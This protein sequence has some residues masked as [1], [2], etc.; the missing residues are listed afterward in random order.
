MAIDPITG[1]ET[2][3]NPILD[4]PTEG[5]RPIWAEEQSV[6]D[7][8]TSQE[9]P[10]EDEFLK[11]VEKEVLRAE[12]AVLV[13]NLAPK[14]PK[15][16]ISDLTTKVL[17]GYKLDLD[18][19]ADWEKLNT[20]IIDLAKLLVKKKTFAGEVVAN[21]KFPLIINACIQ[22]AARAYPEIVKGNEIVKGKVIGNDP[23]GTKA[24][25]AKRICDFMSFQVLNEMND[26]EEG[27][28]QLLFTLPA[29]GCVFKKS[30]FDSI[31]R[32]NISETVFAD[33]VIVNYKVESLERAPRISHRIYL[34][35]NEIVERINSGVFIDF[36]ID[37]LGQAT[38]PDGNSDEETPHLFIEQHRWYDLD[39]DGYQEP[40]IVTIHLESQKLVRIVPR[41]ATDGI[42]RES[43][44]NGV[45]KPDGKI[46]K[47]IPEQY[48]TRYIFMPSID[49]GFYGMGFGSLLMSTNSAINTLIN[50][51]LDAGTLSNRQSGF[52]G[53]GLKI[54][55][56]KSVQLKA[57]EWKHI[58]ST[59]EDIKKNVF[60]MQ[61][62]EPSRT[63]FSLLG[64][65]IESG[66]ELA[67]MT[68]ILAGNSP[69]ANVPAE[70][71]VA[72]IEQGLQVYSA[73]HKRIYRAQYKEF[74]KIR[75]LNAL[76]LDQMT[77]Q[78]VLD[79]E[80]ADIQADFATNDFD[81]VP[82]ADP[83]N[84]TMM[85]RLMKAKAMLEL[86]G[87]GLNDQEINRR[88]LLAMEIQDIDSLFPDE[89]QQNPE[90]QLSI[91]KLQVE[92]E[93]LS[94]KVE[95]LK[96]ETALNYAKIQSEY[97]ER[98]KT[99]AG[100]ENDDEKIMLESAQVL[101]QINQGRSQQSLGKAPNGIK[102]ST[103]KRE[104][105]LETNNQ[106]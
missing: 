95:K 7:I 4:E 38:D 16:V 42:I 96:S 44:E 68:E 101:N 39:Q 5:S 43:D 60:P 85:Q 82:V 59:G 62:R 23:E 86:R 41:F 28:D 29:I 45:P 104:Y 67:G 93:E 65:L 49:G 69:G 74:S 12:A 25:R 90:E 89:E 2:P 13:V 79:D 88:Y 84:T 22:F 56:G 24:D 37:E 33:D 81:V 34:Y 63:L 21:V 18:S 92:I 27:V 73:V 51:L 103:A 31:E 26:W 48:F 91:Q 47:I 102:L 10:A 100:I 32:R 35:H 30:Y 14:Q 50:Q 83:N 87:G 46:I 105:G 80:Q 70:S 57:G 19:R 15:E 55:R 3:D 66:K 75:R 17:E 61:V 1:L 64:L 71:V 53:R 6:E 54:G 20:Q 36:D 99:A 98:E 8:L 40:Y 11:A 77:Y 72:L 52:L 78:L 97:L 58:E 76:Y 9:A 106:E 94:E